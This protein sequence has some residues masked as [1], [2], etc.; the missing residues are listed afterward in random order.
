MFTC[1]IIG[2]RCVPTPES[3]CDG[4]WVR[5]IRSKPL[6]MRNVADSS[7]LRRTASVSEGIDSP[8][9]LYAA[10][11]SHVAVPAGMSETVAVRTLPTSSPPSN[12]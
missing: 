7:A 4:F 12:P 5:P 2:R 9:A 3:V 1:W 6:T 10:T 8:P 11:R